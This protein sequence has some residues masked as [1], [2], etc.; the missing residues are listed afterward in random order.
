MFNPKILYLN[1]TA[2]K[3]CYGMKFQIVFT[4]NEKRTLVMLCSFQVQCLISHHLAKVIR[5]NVSI[6]RMASVGQLTTTPWVFATQCYIIRNGTKFAY[7]CDACK[8]GVDRHAFVTHESWLV[9]R[10]AKWWWLPRYLAKLL[11]QLT[12]MITCDYISKTVS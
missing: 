9:P 12:C 7:Y 5:C 2:S 10:L 11:Q 4:N 3:T 1:K 6:C 8:M